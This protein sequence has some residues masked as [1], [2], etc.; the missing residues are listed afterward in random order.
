MSNTLRLAIPTVQPGG[1]DAARSDHF[2]H[3]DLFTL[4]EIIDSS[5]AEVAI[6]D[7]PSHGSDGCMVPVQHLRDNGVNAVVVG[8][9]GAKPLQGFNLANIA[10]YFAKVSSAPTVEAVVRGMLAGSFPRI[11]DDQACKGGSHCNH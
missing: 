1:M 4:V 8:G 9:I 6:M 5:V 10:V 2:G 11:R 3:C 7:N